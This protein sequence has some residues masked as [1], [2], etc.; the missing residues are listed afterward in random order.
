M[1]ANVVK[2][3]VSF[4]CVIGAILTRLSGV[5]KAVRISSLGD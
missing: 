3:V 5:Q 4:L 1:L 2:Y